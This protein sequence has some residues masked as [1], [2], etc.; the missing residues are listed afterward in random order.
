[1][2]RPREGCDCSC[3]KGLG[4]GAFSRNTTT[5]NTRPERSMNTPI[6]LSSCP[7]PSSASMESRWTKE[8]PWCYS[9]R[10][11]LRAT[12]EGGGG[13][14][15]ANTECPAHCYYSFYLMLLSLVHNI[16]H[17]KTYSA[18]CLYYCYLTL[19]YICDG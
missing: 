17:L 14:G 13:L 16:L 7:V 3:R 10:S 1:M 4:T 19:V 2:S 12:G 9:Q 8:P 15:G 11:A 18:K 6:I 5:V